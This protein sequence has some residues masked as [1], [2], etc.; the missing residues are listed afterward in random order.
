MWWVEQAEQEAERE[1]N[2]K[3]REKRARLIVD[4]QLRAYC[5]ALVGESVPRAATILDRAVRMHDLR[6]A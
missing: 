1:R 2:K 3:Y 4:R 5:T 6:A